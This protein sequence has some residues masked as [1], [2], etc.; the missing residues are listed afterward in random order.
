MLR[1]SAYYQ[2]TLEP[3]QST[4]LRSK[5]QAEVTTNALNAHILCHWLHTKVPYRKWHRCCIFSGVYFQA[6]LDHLYYL[7]HSKDY[8]KISVKMYGLGNNDKRKR[9]LSYKWDTRSTTF[10]HMVV[11]W[12]IL[13]H[14]A[15]WVGCLH[16]TTTHRSPSMAQHTAK[17]SL[18]LW[19]VYSFH[20]R[21]LKAKLIDF[22]VGLSQMY[23][24][25]KICTFACGHLTQN[26][27]GKF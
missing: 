12:E 25:H 7:I 11:G 18:T 4:A 6:F 20:P 2:D 16:A 22:E 8:V 14:W 15:A 19:N 10:K 23:L 17:R 26:S 13:K 9:S 1:R 24:F 21:I 27:K 3:V 5:L